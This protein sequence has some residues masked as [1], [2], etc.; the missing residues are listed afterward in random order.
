VQQGGVLHE[1][2]YILAHLTLTMLWLS[3]NSVCVLAAQDGLQYP[4]GPR[5]HNITT[6]GQIAVEWPHVDCLW[7]HEEVCPAAMCSRHSECRY[8]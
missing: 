5:R 8:S 7:D 6:A 3:P 1:H 4:A 2:V